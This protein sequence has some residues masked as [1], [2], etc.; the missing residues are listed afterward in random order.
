MAVATASDGIFF[1]GERETETFCKPQEKKK[2]KKKIEKNRKKEK[3]KKRE[4]YNFI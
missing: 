1:F 2:K 3:K 4:F